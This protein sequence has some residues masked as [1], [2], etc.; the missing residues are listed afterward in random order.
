MGRYTEEDIILAFKRNNNS[1]ERALSDLKAQ[2]THINCLETDKVFDYVRTEIINMGIPVNFIESKS[3][4]RETH[5]YPRFVCMYILKKVTAA[6][7]D[8][9]GF[10]SGKK[11]HATVNHGVKT[12]DNL[13]RTDYS[14][15]HNW[16]HFINNTI[17]K[18]KN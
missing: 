15:K 1:I 11:D 14:F 2:E 9:I 10:Y 13:L 4:K 18:L 6:T 8:N 7:L 17:N 5:V 3:R 16:E 12:V